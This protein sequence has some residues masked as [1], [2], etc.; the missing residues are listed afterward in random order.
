MNIG[1]IGGGSWGTALAKLL[2]ENGHDVLVWCHEKPLPAAINEG[3]ENTEYLPGFT[4]PDNL[5]ATNDIQETIADKE[6]IVSVVPSHVLRKVIS[7]VAD[8]IPP[9][10]PI[11]SATKGIE[12]ETQMLVS[13][14][15]EDVLPEYCHPYLVYLSGPSFAKEV[16]A[17]KPT[18]VTVASYNHKLA[19][20][21]QRVFS[22]DV[23]RAYTSTDVVGVE[24]GGAVKN[25]I[26]IAAGAVAGME[27]GLNSRAG[28]ITRGLHEMS[29]LAVSIGANP[30]TLSG[31][32]GMGDLVLTCTGGLSRNRSVGVKLGQGHSLEEI[33]G[34]MN[35][36]AEGVKTSKS[37]HSLSQKLGVEMPICEK[38]YQV[39]YE[40]LSTED[41]V[42]EL[43]SRELKPELQGLY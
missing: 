16:A 41:A 42:T 38:V 26:A 31:L 18:A 14:I 35:M 29:R 40:G 4:L 22:N 11:V 17:Q 10:T 19:E 21:V 39:L 37:V 30:L 24:I 33:V 23:F 8:D 27:L 1:V 43:M 12:N 9:A 3:H 5:R 15:L 6:M 25:V 32:A 36:V 20:R 2:A 28:M 34:G 7:Q 13:D